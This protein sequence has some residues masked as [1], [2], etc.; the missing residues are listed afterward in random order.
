MKCSL[1]LIIL[2]FGSKLFGQTDSLEKASYIQED[3]CQTN[4]TSLNSHPSMTK[5]N[6]TIKKIN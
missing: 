6:Q 2:F 5:W 3:A 4:I 1:I